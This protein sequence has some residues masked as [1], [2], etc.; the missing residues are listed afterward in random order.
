MIP[1]AAIRG[2]IGG[3]DFW[4]EATWLYVDIVGRPQ[5]GMD[6]DFGPIV[7][8]RFN[9]TDDVKDAVVDKLPELDTAIEIGA[10]GGVSWH[11]LT[12]PYDTLEPARGLPDRRRRGA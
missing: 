9:R 1:A 2:R 12:N 3:M 10:F 4:T 6:W 8:G 5:S 7:G 11:G